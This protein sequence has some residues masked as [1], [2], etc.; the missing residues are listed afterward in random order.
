MPG[1]E[2]REF[3]V[4]VGDLGIDGSG[5][6]PTKITSPAWS[7]SLA[8][9][10]ETVTSARIKDCCRCF[11]TIGALVSSEAEGLRHMLVFGGA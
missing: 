2:N 7:N 8:K 3:L 1:L 4:I 11:N 5:S 9:S 10:A 6:E